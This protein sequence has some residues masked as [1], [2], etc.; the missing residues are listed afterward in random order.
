MNYGGR[1]IRDKKKLLNSSS[2]KL[3]NK[4]GVF[5]IKL[6]LIV[7]IALVVGVSCLAFGSIQGIIESAPDIK[8]IDVSPDGFA[9][10]VYDNNGTEIQTLAYSGANRTYVTLD[11]IPEELQHA[12]VAI[13]DERFYEHNGIDVKGIVRAGAIAVSNGGLSQGASTITQQLLKNNVFNAYNETTV[14]K[15]KRKIQEQYLAV[16]LETVM[17]KNDILE[18]Y[19]N[20]INLGNGYY[21]V[22]AA[23]QGYFNKDVSELNLS[24]CAVIASITKNPTGLNPITNPDKNRSREL[25]VLSNMLEQGYITQATYDEAIADDVYARLEGLDVATDGSS[26]YSYFVD[27]VIEQL[28]TDLME[29][30]GYT[31]KQATNMIYGGGLQIYTTQDSKMQ[32]IADDTINDLSNWPRSTQ[33]SINLSFAVKSGDGTYHYY[34]HNT[35]QTW[36]NQTR[37]DSSFSLTQS[38][39]DR[40]NE[41]IKEYEDAMKGNDGTITNES[42]EFV[43]QPQVS[44]SL[45]EQSTGYVKVLVGGRGEK[46]GNR[47]LN[48]ATDDVT[49]Q[50]GSSIKPLVAYGPALD[51]GAITLATAID[52]APYYYSGS[53]S[54]LVTN[55]DKSYRGIMTVREAI[56]ISENVPAVKVLTAITP[57]VGF[58]YLKSFGL[59]TLVS[60]SDAINGSHDV[61]QSLALGGMTKGVCNIDMTAAY[62]AIANGGTYTKPIYYTQVLDNE[63]NVIIDNSTPQT[64]R[65]L[66]ETTSWL[67]TSALRSVVT[68]GTATAAN[69]SGQPAC[70]K[71]GTT[72]NDTDK[73]F[74]GFTPY[75][76]ASI[77]VGYDDNST[78]VNSVNHTRIWGKIMESINDYTNDPTG[79]YKEPEGITQAEVCNKSGKLPSDLCALDE[80]GSTHITEYFS[81]DNVP[82][83]T[84]DV[85]VRVTLC[86]ESGLVA[87]S[88][89]P[90]T[91]SRILTVKDSAT[92]TLGGDGAVN[93]TTADAQYSISRDQL[94]K[95]CNL[96][97]NSAAPTQKATDSSTEATSETSSKPSKQ[98]NT[99]KSGSKQEQSTANNHVDDDD[100]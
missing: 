34:N 17:S 16:K 15:V 92:T 84:C 9:T 3:E 29:Q 70:G 10:K 4:L 97:S 100:D 41:L 31:E 54:K 33:F 8:S 63:G 23:A 96:H 98:N 24:E 26:T 74:C 75:Y 20:T 87:A 47:T 27:E 68:N 1:G 13:E 93:Y 6:V 71:T 12:F 36:F 65:V 89:C 69:I 49:R 80:R 50:P 77:W 5:G 60:P 43:V 81:T 45:M 22:Q 2:K 53:E 73:W 35:M 55:Y 42:I 82:K 21:G 46:T 62:A 7:A 30:Y 19:L 40:A 78:T 28:T 85:H 56:T 48:R 59:S 64:H 57:Q 51:T 94:T 14:E 76:S 90:S 91:T 52:D 95:I 37:G 99:S 88:G 39:E 83:D 79:T 86:N 61:V 72:Q 58:N 11:Q 44:F 67:L 32:E 25:Q 38:S 18:N 66:K